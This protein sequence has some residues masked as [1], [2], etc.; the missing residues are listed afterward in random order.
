[1]L[2]EEQYQKLFDWQA[3]HSKVGRNAEIVSDF[4][5]Y[6]KETYAGTH[7]VRSLGETY[8][9]PLLSFSTLHS[10][11]AKISWRLVFGHS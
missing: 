8:F 2:M 11:L 7:L 5:Q 4:L 9:P 6:V 3:Q 10:D 1:M